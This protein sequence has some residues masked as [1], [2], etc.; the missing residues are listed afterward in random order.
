MEP[1]L[2]SSGMKALDRYAINVLGIPSIALMENAGR[3]VADAVCRQ[4][5]DPGGKS[6][7][8][9]CG[10]GNNGGDG[11]V[12][13]RHLHGRRARLSIVMMSDPS[14]LKGDAKRNF[15][16][17]KNIAQNASRDEITFFRWRSSRPP[18]NLPGPDIVID[19]IFGTGFSGNVK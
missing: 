12:A 8:V 11:L 16:A 2:T 18:A 3:G 4:Y 1:V 6:V 9:F 14:K 10:K 7:V 15:R 17:L 19:G 13:A 5:G